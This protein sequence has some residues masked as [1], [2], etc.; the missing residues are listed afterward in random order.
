MRYSGAAFFQKR[1]NAMAAQQC[2][3]AVAIPE[4]MDPVV[5]GTIFNIQRYSTEDGPGIRTTVFLKGCPLDCPWC[6]NPEG[7]SPDPVLAFS[8]VRCVACGGCHARCDL[9]RVQEIP[10]PQGCRS[11]FTC[12]G[13]C[14]SGAR[15]VLGRPVTVDGVVA[16]LARDRIFYDQ[17]RGGATFSGGE[18]LAQPEFLDGL[19]SECRLAG[20]RTA[21]DTCGHADSETLM[22]LCGKADLVLYDLKCG[23]DSDLVLDNLDA[24]AKAHRSIWL[25]LPVV[26][27]STDCPVGME[28]LAAR[29]S[30]IG[31]IRRVVLLPYHAGGEAKLKRMGLPPR[32][33]GAKAPTAEAMRLLA[34]VWH[35]RGFDVTL[36]QP[37]GAAKLP[38]AN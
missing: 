5:S 9:L 15:V 10:F 6:H 16:E 27:G 3:G 28:R 32:M 38:R 8:E 2:G 35:R 13:V 36:R 17:S 12:A 1:L 24:L 33:P 29:Y 37:Q 14:P 21:I 22:V 23:S 19:L 25:R 26:P 34:D 30:G 7:L 20:I 11:C 31:S 4:M 18:P